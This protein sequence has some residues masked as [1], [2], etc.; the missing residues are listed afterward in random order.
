MGQKVFC[1]DD[2]G[3]RWTEDG[4]WYE[5]DGPPAEKAARQARDKFAKELKARGEKPHRGT[6]GTQLVSKG[7]I[8]SGKSHIEFYTKCYYV[9]W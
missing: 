2:F 1:G 9:N 6:L 7:G 4:K 5:Y 3:F 8:G